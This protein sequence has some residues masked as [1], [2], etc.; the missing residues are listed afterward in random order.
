MLGVQGHA[1]LCFGV[2]LSRESNQGAEILG[3]AMEL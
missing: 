2:L 1:F 3:F